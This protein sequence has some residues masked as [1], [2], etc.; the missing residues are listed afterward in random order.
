[1]FFGRS[2]AML[3]EILANQKVIMTALENIKAAEA[4]LGTSVAAAIAAQA[5]NAKALADAIA[6]SAAAGTVADDSDDLQALAD[7]M[8]AKA[9]ALDAAFNP[10]APGTD[11]QAAGTA[12]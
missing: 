5:V 1:M 10:P 6:K 4:K 8:T 11:T 2:R 7:D 3:R 12:A 9:A